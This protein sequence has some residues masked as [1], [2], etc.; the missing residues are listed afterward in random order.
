M[1]ESCYCNR[2]VADSK[3]TKEGEIKL[4][5]IYIKIIKRKMI[6]TFFFQYCFSISYSKDGKNSVEFG[7][8]NEQ[9]CIQWIE[10]INNCR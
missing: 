3:Q 1:L 8:E 10:S 7:A 2:I 6:I 4:V 9:E 5:C